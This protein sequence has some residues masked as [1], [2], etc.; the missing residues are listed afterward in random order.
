[1]QF[2]PRQSGLEQVRRV[3]RAIGFP[4]PHQLMHFINKKDDLP[5]LILDFFKHRFQAFFKF[6]TIFRARHQRAHIQDQQGFIQKRRWHITVDDA[7]RQALSN[8][9][10]T[11]AGLADQDG[12]VFGAA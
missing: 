8:S 11:N 7:L 2:A 5:V 10:F 12:V 9:G 1:M 6:A 3:H 4:R